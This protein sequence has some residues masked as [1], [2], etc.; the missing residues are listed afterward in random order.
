MGVINKYDRPAEHRFINTYSPIPFAELAAAGQARQG[1]LDENL[2]KLYAA[3]D[4]VNQIDYIANSKD[5]ARAE[6]IQTGMSNLADQFINEDLSDPEIYRK[7]H[8][9]MRQIVDPNEIKRIEQSA[10]GWRNYKQMAAEYK[11]K[12]KSVFKPFDFT[13]YSTADSGIFTDLPMMNIMDQAHD[14]FAEFLTR[15]EAKENI[16]TQTV[17]GLPFYGTRKERSLDEINRLIQGNVGELTSDLAVQQFM[18]DN[19]L[20]AAGLQSFLRNMAPSYQYEDIQGLGLDPR[21]NPKGSEDGGGFRPTATSNA[22]AW[23][24]AGFGGEKTGNAANRAI[25][26]NIPKVDDMFSI[27]T[28]RSSVVEKNEALREMNNKIRDIQSEYRPRLKAAASKEEYNRIKEEEETLKLEAEREYE[29]IKNKSRVL[30]FG[31]DEEGRK[32]REEYNKYAEAAANFYSIEDFDSLS[33]DDK[34]DKIQDYLNHTWTIGRF[35]AV[36]EY[37]TEELPQ[38]AKEFDTQMKLTGAGAFGNRKTWDSRFPMN[39][40]PGSV[41]DLLNEYPPAQGFTWIPIGESMGLPNQEMAFAKQVNIVDKDGQ[42]QGTHWISGT[43]EEVQAAGYW[44]KLI[45]EMIGPTLPQGNL[46]VPIK[47]TKEKANIEWERV[48]KEGTPDVYRARVIM[49]DGS[50]IDW[51][52]STRVNDLIQQLEYQLFSSGQQQ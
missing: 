29:N 18:E 39:Q 40:E 7:L 15:P 17:D 45:T 4:A 26:K 49:P 16:F 36:H 47:G 34:L 11:A 51:L 27:T 19:N 1:R 13:D 52:E 42:S 22:S 20:D 24:P 28:E 50:G 31:S 3:Q 32:K 14:K 30:D 41:V 23:S 21:F 33:T 8:R 35:P 9:G 5:Q 43:N 12:G 6:E 25:K 10:A 37:T 46:E 2:N 48:E 38:Q 44:N